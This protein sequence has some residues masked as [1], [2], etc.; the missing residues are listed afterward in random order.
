MQRPSDGLHLAVRNHF[1]MKHNRIFL[2]LL[3]AI[4]PAVLSAR[5]GDVPD[6]HGFSLRKYEVSFSGALCPGRAGIGYMAP[7]YSYPSTGLS[8][9]YMYPAFSSKVYESGS[10]T[11]AFT[12]NFNRTLALQ[13]SLSYESMWRK[14]FRDGDVPGLILPGPEGHVATG[15]ASFVTAMV[16]LRASWLNRRIVRMYSSFGLGVAV[17]MTRPVDI[18]SGEN[19]VMEFSVGP[20][21]QL[22]AVG[23]SVGKSLFGFAEAG[24]GYAYTGGCLGIGYRF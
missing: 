18:P 21:F 6:K 17:D 15:K 16:S 13:A 3:M 20:A 4:V 5:T 11:G 19:P 10:W 2:T 22:C 14:V 1:I 8:R 23:I 7:Y 24:I 12:Y 9:Y